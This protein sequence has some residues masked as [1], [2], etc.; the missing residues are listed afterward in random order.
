MVRIRLQ[1]F[2]ET[3]I[4]ETTHWYALCVTDCFQSNWDLRKYLPFRKSFALASKA[5]AVVRYD[6]LINGEH[7]VGEVP[8]KVADYVK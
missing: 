8:Q 2:T 5:R 7:V 3:T 4:Q 1:F 6:R